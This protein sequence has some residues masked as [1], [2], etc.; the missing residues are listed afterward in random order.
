MSR[1]VVLALG[2][3]RGVLDDIDSAADSPLGRIAQKVVAETAMLLYAVAPLHATH[4]EVET[5]CARL[6]SRLV[7]VAR[8]TEVQAAKGFSVIATANDRD[9]GV[10]DL[11]SALRRRFNTVVLPLPATEDEEVDIVTRRVAELGQ[12][13]ELPAVPSAAEEVRR[14][15]TVFRRRAWPPWF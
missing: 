8:G 4:P 15:V 2:F 9:R 12:T 13:L 14:V 6:A 3:A 1:Q 7:P 11:S 10:N 5:A